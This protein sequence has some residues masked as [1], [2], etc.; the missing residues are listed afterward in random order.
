[1]GCR[2]LLGMYRA[3]QLTP[4]HQRSFEERHEHVTAMRPHASAT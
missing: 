3:C 2:T 1:V 4:N